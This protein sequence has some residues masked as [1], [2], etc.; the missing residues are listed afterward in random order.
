MFV[1]DFLNISIDPEV[2]IIFSH[3]MATNETEIIENCLKS[4]GLISDET[5]IANHPWVTNYQQEKEK[6]DIQNEAEID[7]IQQRI[8]RKIDDGHDE[9]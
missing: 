7:N 9:A 4:K 5:I 2:E 3:D 1:N 6:L 8:T